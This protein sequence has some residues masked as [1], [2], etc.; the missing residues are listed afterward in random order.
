MAL[1]ARDA[2][3]VMRVA[4]RTK[5][6]SA[7]LTPDSVTG[8]AGASDVTLSLFRFDNS[9]SVA[10]ATLL[11]WIDGAAASASAWSPF[12]PKPLLVVAADIILNPGDS[13]GLASLASIIG[14]LSMRFRRVL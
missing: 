4:E 13:I 12:R 3:P 10:T 9:G 2:K 8:L 5:L 7:Y 14:C 1:L 6:I 11:A